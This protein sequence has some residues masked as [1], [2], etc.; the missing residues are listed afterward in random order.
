METWTIIFICIAIYLLSAFL[1]WLHTHLGHSSI[2]IFSSM[3]PTILDVWIALLPFVNTLAVCI[4]WGASWPI[5][6]DMTKKERGNRRLKN[7]FLIK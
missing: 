1:M 4:A 2:G 3:S 6:D 5:E 7:F